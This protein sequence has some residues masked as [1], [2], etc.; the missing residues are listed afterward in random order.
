MPMNPLFNKPEYPR[1]VNPNIDKE[2][3]EPNKF[4]EIKNTNHLIIPKGINSTAKR[5]TFIA[6]VRQIVAAGF[7]MQDCVIHGDNREEKN[8]CKKLHKVLCKFEEKLI[9]SEYD[10]QL[11]KP[12]NAT[13]VHLKNRKSKKTFI[14]LQKKDGTY[15]KRP[16]NCGSG[17]LFIGDSN[18]S[19][20][21]DKNQSLNRVKK[22]AYKSPLARLI[23]ITK[24]QKKYFRI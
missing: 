14:L 12:L 23:A 17:V 19:E 8:V 20:E 5:E 21:F 10:G 11:P 16:P 9:Q 6:V 22:I 3:L 2:F 15:P 7:S 13:K 1:S 4:K 18:P 24:I